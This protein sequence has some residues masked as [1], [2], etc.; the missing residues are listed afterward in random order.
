MSLKEYARKRTF[1]RTPEPPPADEGSSTARG[2]GRRLAFVVAD[3]RASLLFL[4]NLGCLD[5]NPWMSRLG[6]DGEGSLENPDFILIDLD[7]ANLPMAVQAWASH[8]Y[9]DKPAP[10]P[11]SPQLQIAG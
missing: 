3:D 4:A 10:K 9:G 7:P 8:K 1:A 2:Q 5:Q 6:A 11:P